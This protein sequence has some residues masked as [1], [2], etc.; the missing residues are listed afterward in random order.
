MIKGHVIQ[1]KTPRKRIYCTS[2][3]G[4]DPRQVGSQTKRKR[5]TSVAS[6]AG[7]VGDTCGIMWPEHPH[8]VGDKFK[9]IRPRVSKLGRDISR[10]LKTEPNS[11]TERPVK[12]EEGTSR[13]QREDKCGHEAQPETIETER[14]VLKPSFCP[15]VA[16]MP[17][18]VE[19]GVHFLS[20]NSKRSKLKKIKSNVI[21]ITLAVNGR[22]MNNSDQFWI[23][24]PSCGSANHSVPW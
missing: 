4:V 23:A 20:S 8:Q 3:D 10:S 17:P 13:R 6:N 2:V 9:I 16:K 19:H 18:S 24:K 21:Q 7:Q 12:N 14:V 11:S 5:E 22:E 15:C 1:N